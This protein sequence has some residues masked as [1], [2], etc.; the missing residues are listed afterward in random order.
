MG[1][2][3]I[4]ARIHFQNTIT[5]CAENDINTFISAKACEIGSFGF[6]HAKEHT[7]PLKTRMPTT[8][9]WLHALQNIDK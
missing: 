3:N 2:L 6:K 5:S 1:L 9:F 4:Q 8:S 7:E